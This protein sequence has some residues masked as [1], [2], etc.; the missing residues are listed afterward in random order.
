MAFDLKVNN[1]QGTPSVALSPSG[2]AAT[3]YN[4][5]NPYDYTTQYKPELSPQL[6]MKYGKGRITGFCRLIGA[7]MPFASDEVKHTEQGRLHNSYDGV[8]VVGDVFTFPEEAIGR[9]NDE[10]IISDG[11]IE[12]QGV[13]S[14]KNSGTE[15]VIENKD[16]GAF[17]FAGPVT[18]VIFSN[19]FNKGEFNFTEGKTWNPEIIT[20][21]PKIIKEF[22]EVSDSDLAHITWV[23]TPYGDMWYSYDL[24]RTTDLYDNKLE[25]T[26]I[27]D[28]RATDASAAATG[29]FAQGMKGIVQQVEERGNIANERIAGIE[30]LSDISYRIKRQGGCREYTI[31]ADHG[32]MADFRRMLGAVNGHYAAGANYGVFQNS[33]EMAL[34]LD[35][36]SV[37]ID[38]V[39]YHIT[40]WKLQDDPTLMGL[41][42]FNATNLAALIVPTGTKPVYEEGQ[43]RQAPYLSIRYRKSGGTD[44]YKKTEFFGGKIGT[45]HKKDTFEML[46][47]TEQTNQVVGANEWFVVRRG[48]G[49]YTGV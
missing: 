29:G 44:R 30:E 10:V 7:E 35:F 38:G 4:F 11:T 5:I 31:F 48:T 25:M 28:K 23:Q 15:F 19:T 8:T 46:C 6:Y 47:T 2:V 37:K 26:H 41:A 39:S 20:N 24:Q 12:A 36:S 9:V 45:P 14:A 22:F 34:N 42:N 18:V 13:I 17:A 40:P 32:Q 3:P 49:I 16:T 27:F 21:Y 33:A 43:D 1:T